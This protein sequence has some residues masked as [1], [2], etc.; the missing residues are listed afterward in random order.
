MPNKGIFDVLL[1]ILL[2]DG[3]IFLMSSSQYPGEHFA[4]SKLR[5]LI[6]NI[7]NDNKVLYIVQAALI[8][9]V[10]T[11]LTLLLEPYS[12]GHMIF[13][14]RVSEALTVLPAIIPA[15]IPGLFVGCLVSNLLGGFGPI[16]IFFGSM[17][18][19]LAAFASRKLR[20][21]SILVPLPPVLF[22]AIIVGGYLKFLYYKDIP[23]LFSM[24]W[25][26]LGQLLA[27]YGLGYPLLLLIKKRFGETKIQDK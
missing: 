23:L 18:T 8:A 25:V 19:L 22:N 20:K 5:R 11:A 26:G 14:F 2:F 7:E 1:I 10:Y 15:S 17:T 3:T 16:D 24:G 6:M 4:K 27:C 21:Y 13:Q 9:G 12:F